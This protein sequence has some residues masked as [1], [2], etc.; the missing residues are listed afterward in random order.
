MEPAPA[1]RTFLACAF[2]FTLCASLQGVSLKPGG[3]ARRVHTFWRCC[4][5]LVTLLLAVPVV[6]AFGLQH[7]YSR[8]VVI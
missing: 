6:Q 8:D 3:A 1:R 5:S 4:V 7:L 2:W